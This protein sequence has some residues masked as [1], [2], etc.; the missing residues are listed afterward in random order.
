MPCA[1][2]K[3][4]SLPL[5]TA[6]RSAL[7]TTSRAAR[8]HQMPWAAALKGFMCA[9]A[10][11]VEV[12]ILSHMLVAQSCDYTRARKRVPP[13][14]QLAIR[15]QKFWRSFVT[16]QTM[17]PLTQSSLLPLIHK[18]CRNLILLM[19]LRLSQRSSALSTTPTI[20]FMMRLSTESSPQQEM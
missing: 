18:Q 17:T 11:G 3:E 7:P 16:R 14:H 9:P 19:T 13:R 15:C 8:T 12:I 5:T 10:R 20:L 1:K 6:D 4:K 2:Q